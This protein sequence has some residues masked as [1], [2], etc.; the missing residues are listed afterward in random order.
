[1]SRLPA[2]VA[3]YLDRD[4][5]RLYEL[6]WKR[7]IASQMASAEMERTTIDI[8]AKSSE[9]EATLRATGTVIRFDGFLTL[10]QE[11]RDDEE[12][13]EGGR[14]PALKSGERV[15]REKIEATQHFTEPPPRYT[16]A[17]LIKKMEELGIGRPSTYAATMGVLRERDYVALDKKRLV[18]Q[19][20]GRLVTSF[21][22]SFF[23]RYVEYDFTADLEEKLDRSRRRMSWKDV[24]RDFWRDF[25]GSVEGTKE[26]R[27]S[28]VID[29]LNEI[30][31]IPVPAPC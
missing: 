10:Y 5:A 26:L 19:D 18:P 17:S 3:R 29:A 11:G 14:L 24:L 13:E 15:E 31:R 12:D 21:L 8:A 27:V 1:M 28:D 25:A 23:R 16:E 9:G 4:Q 30:W 22:E 7:T 20:K 2:D 6:I